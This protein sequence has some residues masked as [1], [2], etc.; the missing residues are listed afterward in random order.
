M[1][2]GYDL[3]EEQT[4]NDQSTGKDTQFTVNYWKLNHPSAQFAY[5]ITKMKIAHVE[6]LWGNRCCT[7]FW[8]DYK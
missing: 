7:H 3:A 8:W 1:S 2:E 6:R 5:R 4:G